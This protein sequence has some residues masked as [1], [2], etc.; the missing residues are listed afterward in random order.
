LDEAYRAALRRGVAEAE[1]SEAARREIPDWERLAREIT[2]SESRNRR[3]LGQRALERIEHPQARQGV[4]AMLASNWTADLLYALRLLRKSPGFTLAAVL[5]LALGIGANAAVFSIFNAVMLRPLPFPE[6]ER[7]VRLW[8]SNPQRGWPIFAVSQ[9]N[10][11]DWRD[12]NQSFERIAAS[13][14]RAFN[15]SGVDEPERFLGLAVSHGFF[16]L[17]RVQPA[18]GR[19][20]LPEEDAAGANTRV[21]LMSHGLWQRRFGADPAIVG[22]NIRLNELQYT[23]IGVLP[24]DFRWGS[25]DLFAPLMAEPNANR[26]DHR[27]SVYGRLKPGITLAQAHAEMETIASRLAQQYPGS[28]AGWTVVSNTF[29]DW[30]IPQET[31]RA[32][33]V[34]LAAVAFVLL[35]ACANVA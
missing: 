18:L 25:N 33:Y 6:P 31:R 9:P 8:E 12:Q 4:I 22:K 15:L 1:A 29:F 2:E 5:T 27:L 7:L 20:F 21:V 24:Q 11:L 34:L 10:F 19:N 35:I 16:P 28:N 32:I 30:L 17:L 26:S 13:I 14:G 3:T 23:V